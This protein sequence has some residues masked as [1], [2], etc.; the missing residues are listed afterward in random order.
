VG[1]EAA[2]FHVDERHQLVERAPVALAP[3]DE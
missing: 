1:G 3:A 2:Q